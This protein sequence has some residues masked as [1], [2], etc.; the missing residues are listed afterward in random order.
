MLVPDYQPEKSPFYY[1][2]KPFLKGTE[3]PLLLIII[4]RIF[5]GKCINSSFIWSLIPGIDTIDWILWICFFIFRR[6]IV[7]D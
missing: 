2:A 4:Y 1:T 6:N 7:E 5:S 3:R